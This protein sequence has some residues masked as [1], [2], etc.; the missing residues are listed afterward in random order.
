MLFLSGVPESFY[1]IE[2]K[3]NGFIQSLAGIP[4]ITRTR[5]ISIGNDKNGDSKK[6][7]NDKIG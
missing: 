2:N 1:Y 4:H 5:L 3:D 6:E 7:Q